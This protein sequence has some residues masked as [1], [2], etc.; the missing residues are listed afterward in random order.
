MYVREVEKGSCDGTATPTLIKETPATAYVDGRNAIGPV[1]TKP[2]T[3]PRSPCTQ[4]RCY[5]LMLSREEFFLSLCTDCCNL[6]HGSGYQENQGGWHWMG[7]MCRSV[8]PQLT[9]VW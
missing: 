2:H 8:L 9:S 3:Q 4:S 6:L 5:E 1:S 7:D